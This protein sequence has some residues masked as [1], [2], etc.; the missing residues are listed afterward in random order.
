MV[1]FVIPHKGLAIG[2]H[3]YSFRIDKSFFDSFEYLE[4]IDGIVNLDLELIK[5]STLM[6]LVFHFK[7]IVQLKCDR[8]LDIFD[9][10]V[11]DDYRLII[12]YGD[13]Y[14]EISDEILIIPSSESKIDIS[15]YVY[16][17]LN[18]MLPLKKVHQD[19]EDGQSLCNTDMLDRINYYS[20]QRTDPRW[21]KLKDIK[22]D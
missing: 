2:N 17:Y 16:E 21:D 8:C 5:E 3:E 20:E 4:I 10:N 18:L 14:E 7:G 1:E 11:E 13:D 12:K 9:L 22:L 19:G 6:S 15:Q